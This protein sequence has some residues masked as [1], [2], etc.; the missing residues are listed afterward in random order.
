MLKNIPLE[1]VMNNINKQN[2]FWVNLLEKI[3]QQR[4]D[5]GNITLELSYHQKRL[6]R[7]KII[8]KIDQ[9]IYQQEE[10]KE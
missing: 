9:I 6:S 7:I 5:Y 8:S 2:S 3:N 1:A 4:P 10:K